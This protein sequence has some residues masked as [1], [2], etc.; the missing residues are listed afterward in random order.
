VHHGAGT[1]LADLRR[2]LGVLRGTPDDANPLP[3]EP[4]QL[5]EALR[6]LAERSR[7]DGLNLT[8]EVDDEV[9]RLDPLQALTVL[10]LV[11][12]GLT[13]VLKHAGPGVAARLTVSA[14]DGVQVQLTNEIA[15]II[16]SGNGYGLVGLDERVALVGGSFQAGPTPGG[17][18]LAAHLPVE[19]VRDEAVL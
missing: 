7:L 5:P 18:R 11:Q 9:S 19:P 6:N 15:N 2:L 4:G 3:I 16:A 8:V 1:A 13:N 10:R 14:A 12:E 17:W